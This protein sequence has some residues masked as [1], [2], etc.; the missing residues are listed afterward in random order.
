MKKRGVTLIELLMAA[1][2]TIALS[3]AIFSMVSSVRNTANLAQA[4]EEA[5]QMAELALKQMQTDIAIS[6]ATIEKEGTDGK[7][8][9]TLTFQDQGGGKWSM[10]IPKVE[11]AESLSDDYV[12]VEYSLVGSK[13]YRDGGVEGKKKLVASNIS[14][15]E[16]F[17]LSQEQL[18]IEVEAQVIPNGQSEPVKH[19]QKVLV[20]VR[21]AITANIDER[22]KTSEE[23]LSDY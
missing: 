23:V 15:L 1:V 7:P 18:A 3:G 14:K 6:H 5:K 17:T 16:V 20:T 11:N 22:W 2:I 8:A 9:A 10:K 21:E 12:D 13:L 4:K 19:N